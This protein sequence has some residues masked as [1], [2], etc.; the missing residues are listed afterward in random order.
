MTE[1]K[2]LTLHQV[3]FDD[4]VD[5]FKK[6]LDKTDDIKSLIN[7][8]DEK[9]RNA[10][11]Y[12]ARNGRIGCFKCIL[13]LGA[14][15]DFIDPKTDDTLLHVAFAYSR[16]HKLI[17]Y[18]IDE[19]HMDINAVNRMNLT[20]LGVAMLFADIDEAYYLV[21]KGAKNVGDIEHIEVLLKY[22]P[23]EI[24]RLE[25]K[26]KYIAQNK[27]KRKDYQRDIAVLEKFLQD[28]PLN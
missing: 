20:I 3:I 16:G 27:K 9:G 15:L 14:S 19:C 11:F 4:D 1:E 10:I 24:Q 26:A 6:I 5:A 13:E 21:C 18:L 17:D 23:L 12:A 7:E 2:L 25:F 22:L 28:N 8:K